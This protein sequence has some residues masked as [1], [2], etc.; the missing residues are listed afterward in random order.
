[1]SENAP[2]SPSSALQTMY[3]CALSSLITASN[4][5]QNGNPAP[6][7]PLKLDVLIS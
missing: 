1:M 7:L 4:L 5:N 6:P 2:G 3:F